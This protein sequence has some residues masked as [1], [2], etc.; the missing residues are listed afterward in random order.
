MP[1][2]VAFAGHSLV[3]DVDVV[4]SARVDGSCELAKE[5]IAVTTVEVVAGLKS[6][7]GVVAPP[8]FAEPDSPPTNVL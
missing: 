3:A 5:C 7:V 4:A 1:D 2:G 6:Q 8:A